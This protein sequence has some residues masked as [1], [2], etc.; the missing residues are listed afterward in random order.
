MIPAWPGSKKAR[1][2]TR[3]TAC[4][5]SRV[6][7]LFSGRFTDAG[8]F[9]H[10]PQCCASKSQLVRYGT[11]VILQDSFHDRHSLEHIFRWTVSRILQSGVPLI[12]ILEQG[13]LANRVNQNLLSGAGGRIHC[14]LII[15]HISFADRSK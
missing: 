5:S 14:L 6:W 12:N 11:V 3:L 7:G 4:L 13:I 10:A 15:V 8:V 1:R 2:E 9:L